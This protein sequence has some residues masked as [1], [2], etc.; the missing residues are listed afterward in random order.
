MPYRKRLEPR[1][2]PHTWGGGA[3]K[4]SADVGKRPLAR[5]SFW[6]AR[7][8][9]VSVLFLTSLGVGYTA[10]S[11]H[12]NL[13]SGAWAYS[14][15]MPLFP[16]TSIGLVPLAQWLLLPGLSVWMAARLARGE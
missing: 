15:F 4:A 16:G 13:T 3:G 5:E 2:N 10:W 9:V 6:L 1:E 12:V 8:T 11:E 14:A 7:P